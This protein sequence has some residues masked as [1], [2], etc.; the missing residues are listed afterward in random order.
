[1]NKAAQ[2]LGKKGGMVTKKKY[3]KK[4]YK[5]LAEHMNKVRRLKSM[6]PNTNYLIK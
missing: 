5:K 1:M 3:G 6:S 2:Q 4:H